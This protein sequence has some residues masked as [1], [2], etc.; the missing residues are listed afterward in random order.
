MSVTT[1]NIE[2]NSLDVGAG[3]LERVNFTTYRDGNSIQYSGHTIG[4]GIYQGVWYN[5]I[6]DSGDF[7]L[8]TN[9]TSNVEPLEPFDPA[10]ATVIGSTQYSQ[11]PA[12]AVLDGVLGN[13]STNVWIGLTDDSAPSLLIQLAESRTFTKYRLSRG[14]CKAEG[15]VAGTWKLYGSDN[16]TSYQIVDTVD[17]D[18]GGI[19]NCTSL[20]EFTIDNP[21]SYLYY[22]FEFEM[23]S[24]N[25]Y[26]HTG[27]SIGELEF[28]E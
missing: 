15:Y 7:T 6:G 23:S 13:N 4:N 24:V 28:D 17:V 16:N 22:K 14:Y 18:Q 20:T 9:E 1:G 27:V 2:T 19:M 11:H 3:S 8:D 21:N 12:S 10:S 5:G 26:T 25:T